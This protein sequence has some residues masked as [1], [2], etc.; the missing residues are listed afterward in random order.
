MR[1]TAAGVLTG[2]VGVLFALWPAVPR[3]P[4]WVLAFTGLL[5]L[6]TLG[7]LTMG[8]WDALASTRHYRRLARRRAG[9]GVDELHRL[10][11]Q[12]RQARDEQN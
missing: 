4:K 1:R 8:V 11:S 7:L 3:Q 9:R 2:V 6:A 5:T 10:V 12:H